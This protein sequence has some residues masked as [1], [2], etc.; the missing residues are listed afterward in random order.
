MSGYKGVG[1]ENKGRCV[2]ARARARDI[3]FITRRGV[4]SGEV[5]TR[6]GVRVRRS[7]PPPFLFYYY[8]SFGK[9]E[10]KPTAPPFSQ[11]DRPVHPFTA[12]FYHPETSSF[13]TFPLCL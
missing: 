7:P 2:R 5:E 4:R 12:R 11:S 1:E 9:F 6:G 3:V 13:L 10:Q 8:S